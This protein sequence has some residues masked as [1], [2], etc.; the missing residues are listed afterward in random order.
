MATIFDVSGQIHDK[1]SM[2]STDKLEDSWAEP[3]RSL[4]RGCKSSSK[5][6]DGPACAIALHESKG[7]GSA[8][9]FAIV[10]FW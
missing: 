8:Q 7:S 4:G 2:G 9:T 5:A 10:V 3:S 6:S 1:A